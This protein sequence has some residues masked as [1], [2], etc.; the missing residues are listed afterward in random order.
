ERLQVVDRRGQPT[1]I[2]VDF[3]GISRGDQHGAD[4]RRVAD[5]DRANLDLTGGHVSEEVPTVG[6]TGWLE[7]CTGDENVRVGDADATRAVTNSAVHDRRLR[8]ERARDQQ[9][10]GGG[11][12]FH[13]H[14]GV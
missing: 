2:E 1:Q 13:G 7:C 6:A 14:G 4:G 9:E 5:D 8:A 3:N 12:E 11:R 10:G